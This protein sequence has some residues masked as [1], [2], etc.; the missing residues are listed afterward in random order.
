MLAIQR[1]DK[2]QKMTNK[3]RIY[4]LCEC[5]T[6]V[7]DYLSNPDADPIE[8]DIYDLKY[9]IHDIMRDIEDE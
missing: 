8:V 4:R 2:E 6:D 7:I 1:Q 9:E 5:L 3:D